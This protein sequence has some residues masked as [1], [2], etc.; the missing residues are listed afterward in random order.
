[1]REGD[2]RE[3]RW[4]GWMAAAQRG[5]AL[6]YER[7]LDDLLPFV[8][9]L[10]RARIAD[11]PNAE[12]VVQEVLLAI[13]TARHTFRAERP[14]EPWVRTIARNAVIDSARRRTRQ[15]A[16]FADVEAADLPEDPSARASAEADPLSRGLERALAKL[17]SPQREAVLLLKVEGLSVVEAAARAG[18]TPGALK[19][20]A[21]R[22]YR[23]LRD[24]LGGEVV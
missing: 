12:D 18:T 6:A 17:P 5:D 19:L 8:R 11:D 24:L 3:A 10:V 1:M 2:E 21:H 22:G 20:R 4:R 14:L 7:L 16:R 13:H 9:G 23:M 15:R